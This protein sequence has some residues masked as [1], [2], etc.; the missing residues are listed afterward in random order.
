M[1]HLPTQP[2][3]ACGAKQDLADDNV[4]WV[5]VARQRGSSGDVEEFLA[6]RP[7]RE[8]VEAHLD[9][10]HIVTVRERWKDARSYVV[11]AL[12]RYVQ[13]DRRE[14]IEA[15]AER[16]APY[17][18]DGVVLLIV[19]RHARQIE[20]VCGVDAESIATRLLERGIDN[21]ALLAP[22]DI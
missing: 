4:W 8:A 16:V 3:P 1:K 17:I 18:R 10:P 12:T 20:E 7:I 2:A 13:R 9:K 5:Y 22:T 11:E 6:G 14:R 19:D 21:P 15:L